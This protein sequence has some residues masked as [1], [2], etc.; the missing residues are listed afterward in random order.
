M[1]GA[2]ARPDLDIIIHSLHESVIFYGPDMAIQWA[3]RTAMES[4]NLTEQD[5]VGRRCHELWYARDDYCP[6]CPVRKAL[7]SG[8]F[9]QGEITTPDKRVWLVQAT[10]VRGDDGRV[11]GIVE[12]ALDITRHREAEEKQARAQAM[13]D[14]INAMIDPVIVFT[15]NG[16]T[17][18]ANRAFCEVFQL[19]LRDF[20][21]KNFTMIPG[22]QNQRADEIMRY[23]PLFREAAMEGRSGPI[24]LPIVR[25]DGS[26]V[27]MSATAGAIRDEKNKITHIVVSLHDMS[28]RKLVE[29]ELKNRQAALESTLSATAIVGED[30]KVNWADDAFLLLWDL[31][32]NDDVQG[33][34]VSGYWQDPQDAVRAMEAAIESGQWQGRLTARK[35]DGRNFHASVSVLILN[36]VQGTVWDVSV[37][38]DQ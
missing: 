12:V 15:T 6:G 9:E 22:F 5:M 2:V 35:R 4:L 26:E 24:E 27:H 13:D 30:G 19:E 10:P 20:M 28:R 7:E 14:L 18:Y 8:E 11:Q 17:V 34:P 29:R 23:T 33:T 21:G 3:N 25:L 16:K 38:K 36:N 1:T 32:S 31:E 37:I